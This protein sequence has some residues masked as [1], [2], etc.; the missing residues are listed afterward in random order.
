MLETPASTTS[1][2]LLRLVPVVS[3]L[4]LSG[5]SSASSSKSDGK[6]SGTGNDGRGDTGAHDRDGEPGGC[7]AARMVTVV[8]YFT[9]KPVDATATVDGAS[10][11]AELPC[12]TVASG[13]HPIAISASGYATFNDA[14]QVPGGATSRTI[15]L[16]PVTPSLASWLE[17]VNSDRMANGA[18]PLQLNNGLMTAAW[19]HAVDMG[20][21]AY[22]AHFDPHGFAPTTRSLLLGSMVIGA[23]DIAVGQ[24]TYVQA[25]ATFMAERLNL[26]HQSPS[27]CATDYDLADHYCDI[28]TPSHNW[29]GLGIADVP[30]SPYKTY[31][32]QEFGD[33]YGY[34]DTTVMGPE[35]ALD[36]SA[37][38]RRSSRPLESPFHVRVRP[39]DARSDP[40]FDR[41]AEHRSGVRVDVSTG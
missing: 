21:K 7:G 25:E 33:L 4:V 6:D 13:V 24:P 34:Y 30:G 28:I 18:G 15:K 8:D 12:L 23:E 39:D 9:G 10:A 1:R 36:A 3:I 31:F 20:E 38:A 40:D 26:P 35:P 19:D 32:D 37:P 14:V 5:C 17:L 16:V 27:D 22:F 29:L 2:A 41:H 11:G